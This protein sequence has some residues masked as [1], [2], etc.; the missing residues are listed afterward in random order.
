MTSDKGWSIEYIISLTYRQ[1]DC[2][3]ERMWARKSWEIDLAIAM[4]PFGGGGEDEENE[5]QADSFDE[6]FHADTEEGMA[7]AAQSLG[8]KIKTR[9]ATP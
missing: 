4:N 2:I 7:H 8:I 3:F 1:F 6:V 9:V 5:E